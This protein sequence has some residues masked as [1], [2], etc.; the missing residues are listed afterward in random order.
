MQACFSW[1][2]R[3]RISASLEVVK[4]CII[5]DNFSQSSFEKDTHFFRLPPRFQCRERRH[6]DPSIQNRSYPNEY[7]PWRNSIS[8]KISEEIVDGSNERSTRVTGASMGYNIQ[9]HG[10][11]HFDE[12]RRDE[13]LSTVVNYTLMQQK[14]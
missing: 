12:R 1:L 2:Q 13:G 11:G 14:N 5:L 7:Y 4:I 10:P 6:G 9:D 3:R 8:V